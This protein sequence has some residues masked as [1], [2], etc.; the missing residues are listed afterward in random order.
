MSTN[1]SGRWGLEEDVGWGSCGR[2]WLKFRCPRIKPA[3]AGEPYRSDIARSQLLKYLFPTISSAWSIIRIKTLWGI[4]RDTLSNKDWT[5][6]RI[7][8]FIREKIRNSSFCPHMDPLWCNLNLLLL[9]W[10]RR[11]CVIPAGVV[12]SVS[13]LSAAVCAVWSAHGQGSEE[14]SNC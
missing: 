9:A 14:R 4:C 13:S 12:E 7:A 11:A 8:N 2:Q 10:T 1:P 3:T 5:E 6:T